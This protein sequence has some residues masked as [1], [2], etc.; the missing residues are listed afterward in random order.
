[1]R[2]MDDIAIR[3][4][5]YRACFNDAGGTDAYVAVPAEEM[6]A[7]LDTMEQAAMEIDKLRGEE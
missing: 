2:D 4:R 5:S 1:M 6:R 3:L 7:I